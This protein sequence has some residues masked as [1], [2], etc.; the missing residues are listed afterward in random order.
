MNAEYPEPQYHG[1]PPLTKRRLTY[2]IMVCAD[3]K[4]LGGG[5]GWSQ[6]N[7]SYG[8]EYTIK[9]F[10]VNAAK[11]YYS[12]FSSYSNTTKVAVCVVEPSTQ[13]IVWA[14][15]MEENNE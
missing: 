1:L 3:T 15:W 4:W 11:Q 13:E 7:N 6:I 5:E 2:T 10:A 8:W 9:G 12:R 14:S